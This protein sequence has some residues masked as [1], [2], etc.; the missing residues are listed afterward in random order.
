[1]LLGAADQNSPHLYWADWSGRREEVL[2]GFS[3]AATLTTFPGPAEGLG[4]CQAA[5]ALTCE[6]SAF[7]WIFL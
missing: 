7:L 4:G 3:A 1:M 6:Q 2:S 5:S